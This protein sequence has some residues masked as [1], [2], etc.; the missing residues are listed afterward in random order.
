M[1]AALFRFLLGG[2]VLA[3]CGQ[4]P[5]RAPAV[6]ATPAAVA[7]AGA[8]DAAR[9]D[10][11]LG[12]LWTK[13]SV[14]PA[15][16]A[17]DATFLRRVTLDLVGTIPTTAEVQAYLADSSA[18]KKGQAI[19]RL[20]AS[21][22]YVEHWVDYWDSALLGLKVNNKVDR[23]SFRAWLRERIAANTPW[24]QLVYQLLTAQGA[25]SPGGARKDRNLAVAGE[26]MV[27]PNEVTAPIDKAD[28]GQKPAAGIDGAT[29]F[30]LKFTEA[31]ADYP[32]TV[33]RVF[34]GV[35]I[36]CA[37]CH[38][39]KTEAWKQTDFQKFAAAALH[40]KVQGDKDAAKGDIAVVDLKDSAKIFPRVQK[41]PELAPIA[42][43]VP[44]AFDGTPLEHGEQTREAFA[45][46]VTSKDSPWFAKAYVNRLW[47]HLFGR[48]F[49]DPVDDIRP[50]NAPIAPEVLDVVTR[51]FVASGYDSKRLLGS[52][53][54]TKAYGLS[55]AH[56]KSGDIELFSSFRLAPL[57]PA[58]LLGALTRATAFD[59]AQKG[60]ANGPQA[61][62]N[63]VRSFQSLFDVDEE[64]DTDDF[65][66]SLAQALTLMNGGTTASATSA[67][68]GTAL[69]D[70]LA[71]NPGEDA[72]IS[73]LYLRVLS[74]SVTP[75]ELARA[76][77]YVEA[78][79]AGQRGDALA[80]GDLLFSLLNSS[81]FF[82]N[83]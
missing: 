72:R 43:A 27:G 35:Q 56:P 7:Q 38:D 18:D 59:A 22:E 19:D 52:L 73:A 75:A 48:G 42:K 57:G 62:L 36:Q 50:S 15:A 77:A 46:W 9:V 78:H 40:F 33:S 58:E 25:Q 55:A 21:P 70:I 30:A 80:Y 81:E 47:G 41:D 67:A 63:L 29:N 12:A 74:R 32:S 24:N 49:I 64:F 28:Q 83:H 1:N 39:H 65:E 45:K 68:K 82:F 11:A 6:P 8:S 79:Q 26:A 69:A 71:A 10:A 23:A 34:L 54:R 60:K 31:P 13:R 37:Q 4:P 17:D 3:A 44:T 66:G 14:T 2:A 61:K 76:K 20:L 16:A 53:A 5:P 51:E